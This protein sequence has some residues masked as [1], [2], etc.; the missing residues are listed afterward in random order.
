[1]LFPVTDNW[2]NSREGKYPAVETVRPLRETVRS[3]D[4]KWCSGQYRQ[5]NAYDTNSKKYPSSKKPA[6]FHHSKFSLMPASQVC[7]TGM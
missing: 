4:Q 6:G 2:P 5:I 3:E 7:A 1:M